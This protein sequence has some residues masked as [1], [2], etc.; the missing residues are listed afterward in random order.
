[1]QVRNAFD[2]SADTQLFYEKDCRKVRNYPIVTV[3]ISFFFVFKVFVMY[4]RC[5]YVFFVLVGYIFFL[6]FM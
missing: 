4:V 1:M 6:P 2:K 5:C 3:V